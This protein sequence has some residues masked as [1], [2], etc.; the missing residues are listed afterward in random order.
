[1]TGGWRRIVLLLLVLAPS[2]AAG[3]SWL[4]VWQAGMEL[5]L[6][7]ARHLALTTV[8]EDPG[9]ADAVAAASWWLTNLE[10][11]PE[12]EEILAVADAGR[13]YHPRR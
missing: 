9:S 7:R 12:P 6:D 10:D 11:L 13:R 5:D 3:A 2:P 8:S 4:E 1:M